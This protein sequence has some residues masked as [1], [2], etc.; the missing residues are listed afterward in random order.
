MENK[1]T[2]NNIEIDTKKATLL[3]KKII[4]KEKNNLKTKQLTDTEMVKSIKKLIEEE[5]QC[6]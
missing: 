1:I 4:I 3:I 5:V 6:Y 2:V